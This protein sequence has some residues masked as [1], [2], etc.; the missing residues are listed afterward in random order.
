MDETN[1]SD[2][3]RQVIGV[4]RDDAP[5]AEVLVAAHVVGSE[6]RWRVG[7]TRV[8]PAASTIKTAIL[9][10]L[11][12]AIDAGALTL[13]DRYPVAASARVPGSGVLTWMRPDLVLSLADLAYLMIA[14]SD[15]TASNL[16]LG[17]LGLDRVQATIVELGMH[18]TELRRPFL[19][20]SVA[21]GEPDN[22]TCAA[23]LVTLMSAIAAGT[24]ATTESCERM[25]ATLAL[26]Q[27]RGRLA[28]FLPATARFAGK[29]GSLD[30][31][32]H[33]SGLLDTPSG[34]LA[35]AVLTRGFPDPYAAE[36]LIGRIAEVLVAEVTPRAAPR[37]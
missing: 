20:R 9:V 33:D 35:V 16:V 22:L 24:A 8:V 23:D 18:R 26:Q 14:V 37:A 21:P 25:R 2:R 10:A 11:Y 7:A 13:D 3:L 6:R 1:L 34:P 29:S 15:N 28:R 17:A 12:R 5:D 32:V 30:G 4:A 19:G 36:A 27:D 31:I